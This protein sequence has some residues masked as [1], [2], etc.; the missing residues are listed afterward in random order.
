MGAYLFWA[1][2]SSG[3]ARRQ[4]V[5]FNEPMPPYR[6]SARIS[7]VSN[8]APQIM[9][10]SPATHKLSLSASAVHNMCKSLKASLLQNMEGAVDADIEKSLKPVPEGSTTSSILCTPFNAGMA[11]RSLV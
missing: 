4:S 8:V 11:C 9:T 2:S 7:N 1:S 3:P 6:R 5:H 10:S